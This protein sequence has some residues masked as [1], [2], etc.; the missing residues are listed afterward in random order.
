MFL[1][2]LG[3]YLRNISLLLHFWH[4]LLNWTEEWWTHNRT[5]RSWQWQWFYETQTDSSGVERKAP[6]CM[7]HYRISEYL[8][9]PFEYFF[10]NWQITDFKN[11]LKG[12]WWN[13]IT[14]SAKKK[15]LKDWGCNS[16][17]CLLCEHEGLG[18]ISTF[19][20]HDFGTFRLI[21]IVTIWKYW[22]YSA[23]L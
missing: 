6:R 19:S 15:T 10:P 1:F 7:L 8:R 22:K 14:N 17:K 12:R 4:L 23:Y 3:L 13:A 21:T 20:K 11:I 2:G 5:L 18:F 16:V 9:S